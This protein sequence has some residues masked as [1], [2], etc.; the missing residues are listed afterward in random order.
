MDK[1]TLIIVIDD[2]KINNYICEKIIERYS[3]DIQIQSFI[4]SEKGLE[5]I[6]QYRNSINLI[7]LDL[8]MPLYDGWEILKRMKEENISIPTVILTS[9][10]NSEDK[11]KS[12]DHKIIVDFMIKPATYKMLTS[13]LSKNN[14]V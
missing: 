4:D 12:R 2:N 1:T 14:I 5:F 7:F 13:I 8:S 9:S 3:S 10:L 11:Y 6:L